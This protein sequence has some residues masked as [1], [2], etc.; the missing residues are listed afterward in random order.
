MAGSNSIFDMV[1]PVII[2]PSSSHTA[3]CARIGRIARLLFSQAPEHAD[4]TFYNSFAHTYQGHGSD[5]AVIGGILDYPVDD[6]RIREAFKHAQEAGLKWKFKTAKNALNHH[7]NTVRIVLDKKSCAPLEMIGISTGGGKIC[8][9]EVNGFE[10]NFTGSLPTLVLFSY[11]KKGHISFI[12]QLLSHADCNIATMTVARK[13]K[14]APTCII[15]E[16]DSVLPEHTL[17]YLRS[18]DSTENAIFLR[19]IDN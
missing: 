6:L 15:I 18:C 7:S 13:A 8:I 14:S 16:L 19:N 10:V 1:G 4:I 3:G 5:L 11:D 2:G 12:T 17:T 9:Q